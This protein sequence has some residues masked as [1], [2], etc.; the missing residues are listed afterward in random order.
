MDVLGCMVGSVE[1]NHLKGKGLHP[2]IGRIPKG[3]GQIDL[4]KWHGLFSYH[5]AVESCLGRPDAC[6]VDAHGVERFSIHDVEGAASVHQHLG[7]P[8]C[9]DDRVDHERVP[10][11]LQ[12]AF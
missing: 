7:E 2:V 4:P 5:N 10:S 3:D 9:A 11:Q 12:D 1:P 8:L 6:S